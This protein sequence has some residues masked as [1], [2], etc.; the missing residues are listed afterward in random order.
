MNDKIYLTRQD[1]TLRYRA[2]AQRTWPG[3]SFASAFRSALLA[4]AA[5]K[6]QSV[7][8]RQI[9]AALDRFI[10]NVEWGISTLNRGGNQTVGYEQIN[11]T[12][13]ARIPGTQNFNLNERAHL[14]SRE[15]LTLNNAF[16]DCSLP[17][18]V[19]DRVVQE[20]REEIVKKVMF[21]LAE[22]ERQTGRKWRIGDVEFGVGGHS[23]SRTAKGA[24]R[25]EGYGDLFDSEGEG[26]SGAERISLVAEITLRSLPENGK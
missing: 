9:Q 23:G 21:D 20:L 18:S 5:Q 3:T 26:L 15:G 12:A 16:A 7:L 19:V 17:V 13:V 14:A 6:D 24:S 2:I 1:D 22:F 25:S 4:S 11:V 8:I 10:P